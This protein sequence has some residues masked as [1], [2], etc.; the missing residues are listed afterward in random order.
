MTMK[1]SDEKRLNAAVSRAITAILPPENMTVSEWADKKRKLSPESSSEVG[2]WRTD[3]TPYL[4]DIM[5]CFSDPSVRQIC[6]VA[7]SQVGK[8]EAVNN[9]IGYIIDQDPGSILFIQPTKIDAQ[10][11]SKLRIAPMIR[12][13][14]SLKKK[15]A[16]AK[17][18]DSANTVLQ[19]SYP[20]GVLT[21]CGSGEAHALCSKPIKFLFGDERDRWETDAGGEGDP[22]SLAT[23]RQLT[24]YNSKAVEVS[25]PTV[26]GSSA[27]EKSY[28]GGTQERWE[29]KCPHCEEYSE[30]DFDSVRFEYNEIQNG[31]NKI[32]DVTEI[33]YVCQKCGGICSENEIKAQPSRWGAKNPEALKLYGKRSFWLTSW[34][35]PWA[36]WKSTIVEYLQALGDTKKLQVVFNTRFGRLWENRENHEDED[37]IMARREEYSA[38]LPDGVLFLTM[39]VDTQDDRL[40]YEVVGYGHFGESWGIKKGII[41]GRPDSEDVWNT[42]DDVINK[43]YKFES[44]KGLKISAVFV[45]EGGHFT[46][47]VRY[48]CRKRQSK[49]VFPIKG[50]GGESVPYTSPPKA[51]KIMLNGKNYGTC[52]VFELGVDSGKQIIMDNLRVKEPGAKYCHFP[53]RDDYGGGYFKGLLSERLVYKEKAKNKWQWEK[54]PGHER[55]EALDCRNYA[56]AAMRAFS[57][58]FDAIE[59][60]LLEADAVPDDITPKHNSQT[61]ARKLPSV[62]RKSEERLYNDW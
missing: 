1:K 34:V 62:R 10:E 30:I 47:E 31:A 20:G 26:K 46:Q 13:C 37:N 51:Q 5:D 43:I 22:W 29:T 52:W 57:P 33:Y 59:K 8:S 6:V 50:R 32:Y 12:D 15:V 25:T 2:S 3:R 54:I 58:D 61:I 53:K 4:R 21:M 48:Q 44:G 45:D 28:M 42:L 41:M 55:N 39:G 35:S 7:S 14:K 27:I 11:Y 9:M 60:R 17:S 38:E 16:P 36:S 40:E 49:K 56:N 19:K 18:R 24:F 23:T